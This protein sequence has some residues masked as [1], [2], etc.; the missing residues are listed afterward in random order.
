[1]FIQWVP[2]YR[3]RNRFSVYSR[4]IFRWTIKGELYTNDDED[5]V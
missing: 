3:S 2:I 5:G 4:R 1:M